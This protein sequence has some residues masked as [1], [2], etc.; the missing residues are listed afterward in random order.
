MA[1]AA[2]AGAAAWSLIV[3][4]SY[5]YI[6]VAAAAGAVVAAAAVSAVAAAAGAAAAVHEYA[7]QLHQAAA[8]ALLRSFC[9]AKDCPTQY[10]ISGHL[11]KICSVHGVSPAVYENYNHLYID[12]HYMFIL[13]MHII[14]KHCSLH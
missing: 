10:F 3:T 13:Y 4:V 14:I 7:R 5:N 8:A 2:A 11:T 6:V 1:A 9:G 12:M